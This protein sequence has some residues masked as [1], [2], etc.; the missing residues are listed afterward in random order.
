MTATTAFDWVFSMGVIYH[1]KD[2]AEHVQQLYELCVPGGA[3]VLES[4]IVEGPEN[5]IPAQRYARMRN[6]WCVP[7]PSQLTHWMDL[8][9]FTDVAVVDITP[10]TS[11]EQRS[12][13]WMRFESLDQSLNPT[14]SNQ[15]I[16]GYPA[17]RRAVVVGYRR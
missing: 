16:E 8:A 5:L 7:T 9:G 2:P 15:T 10:T 11:Q 1:R 14:N 17:P 3:A 4:L 13:P 12:T 6:V